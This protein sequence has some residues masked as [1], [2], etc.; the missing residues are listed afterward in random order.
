MAGKLLELASGFDLDVNRSERAVQVRWLVPLLDRSEGCAWLMK[1]LGVDSGSNEA[2]AAR[3]FHF[4]FPLG[5]L[6]TKDLS[7]CLGG[8]SSE[9]QLITYYNDLL[10]LGSHRGVDALW[11]AAPGGRYD[12]PRRAAVPA[13]MRSWS[14]RRSPI[15]ACATVSRRW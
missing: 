2:A 11:H 10:E 12:H 15:P 14:R 3:V 6:L 7:N 1:R 8:S 9:G 4:V 5:D 13:G